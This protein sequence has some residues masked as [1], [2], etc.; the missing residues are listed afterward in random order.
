MKNASMMSEHD[1]NQDVQML[2]LGSGTNAQTNLFIAHAIPRTSV[3]QLGLS[4]MN[5]KHTM[6]HRNTS[7]HHKSE[8]GNRLKQCVGQTQLNANM[9]NKSSMQ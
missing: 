8:K 2:L 9:Q 1:F 7:K 5:T 3:T 4:M 6:W